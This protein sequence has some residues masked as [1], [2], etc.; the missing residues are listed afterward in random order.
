MSLIFRNV[1]Q[2]VEG[3]ILGSR[4]TAVTLEPGRFQT[5]PQDRTPETIH[6][7]SC[8]RSF[9]V[10]FDGFDEL[11][12]WNSLNVHVFH[13]VFFTVV[14]AYQYTK[15]GMFGGSEGYTDT[16]GNGDHDAVYD[17]AFTDA[18]DINR[19]LTYHQN[20]GVLN[21]SPLVEVFSFH[22]ATEGTKNSLELFSD[23]A[24]LKIRYEAFVKTLTSTSYGGV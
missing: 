11:E 13:K 3:L 6:A 4:G 18:H 8:E 2:Q 9:R 19:T 1:R 23:R 12:P 10:V 5:C 7:D 24:V 15:G 17:R 22:P 16:S 20:F 14:I 21:A